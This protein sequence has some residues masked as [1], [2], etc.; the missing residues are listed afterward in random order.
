MR[1]IS[2]LRKSICTEEHTAKEVCDIMCKA[3]EDSWS[4]KSFLEYCETVRR[5]YKEYK[6]NIEYCASMYGYTVEWNEFGDF[7]LK[8]IKESDDESITEKPLAEYDFTKSHPSKENKPPQTISRPCLCCGAICT[9]ED[10]RMFAPASRCPRF[11]LTER[12]QG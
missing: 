3:I 12:G 4:E 10:S 5:R 7:R 11:C 6:N 2:E 9:P 8:R 1:T